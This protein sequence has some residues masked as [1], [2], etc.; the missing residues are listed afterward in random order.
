[1]RFVLTEVGSALIGKLF[2]SYTKNF[3]FFS[4][5]DSCSSWDALLAEWVSDLH[6]Q[7]R[8]YVKNLSIFIRSA[9]PCEIYA[10]LAQPARFRL[11]NQNNW[12]E[13]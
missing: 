11:E 2:Q 5:S 3:F 8:N 12:D 1:M 9:N 10:A 7:T 4:L 13:N 6:I